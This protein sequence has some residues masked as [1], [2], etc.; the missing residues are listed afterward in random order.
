[1]ASFSKV[2]MHPKF[3][4]ERLL[5]L[6]KIQLTLRDCQR[7]KRVNSFSYLPTIS[8]ALGQMSRKL[9]DH[10]Y[11]CEHS[12]I[13]QLAPIAQLAGAYSSA[14]HRRRIGFLQTLRIVPAGLGRARILDYGCHRTREASQTLASRMEVRPDRTR[15]SGLARSLR[16]ARLTRKKRD[17]G[18]SP[19][20]GSDLSAT[21]ASAIIRL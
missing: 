7:N 2:Q 17:P 18:S 11:F 6:K 4:S 21:G 16:P 15:Q 8:A 13:P 14:S 9:C 19:G 3:A 10:V 5:T 12:I 20:D 1:M